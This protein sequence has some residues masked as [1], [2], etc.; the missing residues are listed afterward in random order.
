MS[1]FCLKL[2]LSLSYSAN[3]GQ[4][5]LV[6][7]QAVLGKW[8]CH[9]HTC[10]IPMPCESRMV[11]HLFLDIIL[12]PTF[13]FQY[14]TH[15]LEPLFSFQ[16]NQALISATKYGLLFVLVFDWHVG[17]LHLMKSITKHRRQAILDRLRWL[18]QVFA[19]KALYSTLIEFPEVASLLPCPISPAS[20]S[21]GASSSPSSLLTSISRSSLNKV[22]SSWFGPAYCRFHWV[23]HWVHRWVRLIDW[24]VHRWGCN[25]WRGTCQC[26]NCL[27][28]ERT[29]SDST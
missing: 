8:F 9:P 6:D 11:V 21:L 23:R 5:R 27:G 10:T 3:I 22:S 4:S 20:I 28:K 26:S 15:M 2:H 29:R 18:V 16:Q 12:H 14:V 19:K 7:R 1:L 13:G 25:T 17:P 24:G